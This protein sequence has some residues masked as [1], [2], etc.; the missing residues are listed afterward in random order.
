MKE[1]QRKHGVKPSYLYL[2]FLQ[3]PLGIGMFR[4]LRN[5]SE[6]PVPGLE[7]GGLLWFSDLTVPDPLYILPLVGPVLIFGAIKVC[8][9]A[10]NSQSQAPTTDNAFTTDD[11]TV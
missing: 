5:M 9:S 8:T 11:T 1:L 7:T 2:G 3:I 4:L 6:I 10:C